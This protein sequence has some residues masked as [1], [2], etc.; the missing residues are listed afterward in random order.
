MY[1]TKVVTYN[2][3]WQ[4]LVSNHEETLQEII[5][6][7]D[8]IFPFLYESRTRRM[9]SPGLSHHRDY[10]HRLFRERGW[11][12]LPTVSNRGAKV[13]LKTM[14][15]TNQYISVTYPFN[16]IDFFTK[17]LFNLTIVALRNEV[18][19]IP[20]YLTPTSE[21][22][23]ATD[24]LIVSFKDNFDS[25]HRQLDSLSPLNYPFPFVVLGFDLKDSP[26]QIFEID[27]TYTNDSPVIDRSIEFPAEYHLAGLGILNFF[28]TYLREQYPSEDA[29]VKIEQDGLIVRLIVESRDGS[30]EVIEK[31]LHEYEMI[32][33]GQQ[34]PEAI[35]KNEKLMF[36]LRNELRMAKFR[37]ETQQDLISLQTGQIDRLL[38]IVGEGLANKSHVTIDFRPTISTISTVTINQDLSKMI[39]ELHKLCELV[40][41]SNPY[42]AKLKDL[43][44]PLSQIVNETNPEI[45]K[46]S[47]AMSKLKD[48]LDIVSDG[49]DTIDKTINVGKKGLDA[50]REL[51]GYYNKVAQWCGLPV[52]PSILTK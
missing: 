35:I 5:S 48:I 31:A 38:S 22:Q 36:E 51:A 23:K 2:G 33:T 14:G 12:D 19:E 26:L 37:I 17:W 15:P 49:S 46:K 13:N 29:K 16:G 42:H 25:I 50:I 7:L 21:L 3:A 10:W 20:I 11:T 34:E 41:S 40:P 28:A 1:I 4:T 32:V 52:V 8:A 9:A 47:T 44:E 27:S 45:V 6:A 18:I 39:S 24:G 43:K 30:S